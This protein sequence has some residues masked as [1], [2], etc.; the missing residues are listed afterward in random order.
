MYHHTNDR[1]QHAYLQGITLRVETN[2]YAAALTPG[3]CGSHR[4]SHYAPA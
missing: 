2:K 1:V 4:Q 3:L